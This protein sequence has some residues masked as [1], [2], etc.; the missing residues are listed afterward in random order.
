[1][2]AYAPN[3]AYIGTIAP[4]DLRACPRPWFTVRAPTAGPDG[5]FGR[6]IDERALV[7][8]IA[9]CDRARL[10]TLGAEAEAS[11]ASGGHGLHGT[12]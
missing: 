2:C 1:M 4:E 12:R 7:T 5:P 3:Q 11:I 10:V 9:E 8:L 6:I